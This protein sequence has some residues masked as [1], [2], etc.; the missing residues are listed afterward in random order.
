MTIWRVTFLAIAVMLAIGVTMA[1]AQARFCLPEKAMLEWLYKMAG[2]HPVFRGDGRNR[3]ILTRADAGNWTLI[4]LEP[5]R[6][7]VIA[8]GTRS[9]GDKGV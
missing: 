6:A 4:A 2:E 5:S 9:R 8:Q 1:L 7:C 3:I